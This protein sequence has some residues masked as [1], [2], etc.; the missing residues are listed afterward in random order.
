MFHHPND[1]QEHRKRLGSLFET[2]PI[3]TN[4]LFAISSYQ[5]AT[6]R[7]NVYLA[8]VRAL[9][10]G[11]GEFPN[12]F[13]YIRSADPYFDSMRATIHLIVHLSR[14]LLPGTCE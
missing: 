6:V 5:N 10:N 4:P 3:D 13:E 12:P 14:C 7:S 11:N 1:R 2:W 8:T 9:I